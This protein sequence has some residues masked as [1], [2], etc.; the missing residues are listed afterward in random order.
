MDIRFGRISAVASIL[1]CLTPGIRGAAAQ[2]PSA[3]EFAGLACYAQ[4]NRALPP[5]AAGEQRVVFIGDSITQSWGDVERDYFASPDRINRGI[6]GQA[7]PQM[8]L[9]FRQ[10]VIALK[11]AAVHI[12]A[13][14]NDLAGNVGPMDL[15]AI[16]GNLASM[17]ELAR[18]NGIAVVL[19][20]VLP[21]SDY[22]WRP[23]LEPGPKILALNDWLAAY[24]RRRGIV[25]V[26]YYSAM[27]DGA[28][29]MRP[30]LAL[31]GVHPTAEGYRLMRPL[32]E[33]GIAAALRQ[34][35]ERR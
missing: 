23:G 15:E 18:A 7:T 21:A 30:A 17:A 16:E 2:T 27:T 24:A 29:G 12:L 4:A 10:D 11:P 32:A 1:S 31:D 28:L 22:P 8:L 35:I 6:S 33:A 20:S 34:G 14:T 19:G 3:M 9:R 26:N 5:P 13:G 25:Y